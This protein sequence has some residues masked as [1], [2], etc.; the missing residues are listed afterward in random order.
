V[1]VKCRASINNTET[2]AFDIIFLAQ[3][4]VASVSEPLRQNR[5]DTAIVEE[6]RRPVVKRR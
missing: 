2:T 4:L 1:T 6:G 3:S 5:D